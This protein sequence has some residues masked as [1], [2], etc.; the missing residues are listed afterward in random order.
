VS[1]EVK[2]TP[3][4][5]VLDTIDEDYAK[6]KKLLKK[7]DLSVSEKK[8]IEGWFLLRDSK[9]SE[10]I[11]LVQKVNTES[12]FLN[13]QKFLVLGIAYNH[14]GN[15]KKALDCLKKS[16]EFIAKIKTTRKRF[17]LL[18]NLF[19]CHL[20]DKNLEGMKESLVKLDSLEIKREIEKIAILRCY[21]NYYS[22]LNNFQQAEFSEL[23]IAINYLKI[24]NK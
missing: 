6:A 1:G 2:E 11:E 5:L 20:N 23:E 16:S 15:F 14:Q 10:A 13:Y 8:I 9:L 21:F 18:Y 17:V 7:L 4:L 19:L 12:G 3:F 22:F 24:K